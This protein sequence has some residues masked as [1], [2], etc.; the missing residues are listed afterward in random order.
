M[1]AIVACCS[2]RS[3]WLARRV[4]SLWVHAAHDGQS[5][6]KLAVS[7]PLIG[8]FGCGCGCGCV[9]A[10]TILTQPPSPPSPPPP[11]K[12]TATPTCQIGRDTLETDSGDDAPTPHKQIL[13]SQLHEAAKTR[14]KRRRCTCKTSQSTTSGATAMIRDILHGSLSTR[15][16]V[17]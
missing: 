17:L 12:P 2:A 7:G 14:G 10:S 15:S 3:R 6:M 13:A 8:G 9:R 1:E 5:N 11:S 4:Q 16:C